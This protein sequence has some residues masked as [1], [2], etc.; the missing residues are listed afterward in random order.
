MSMAGCNCGNKTAAPKTYVVT[1]PDKSTRS[2]KT[3][4]EAVA[5]AKRVPGATYRAV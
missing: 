4:V 5:A 3:E 2:Y 1:N